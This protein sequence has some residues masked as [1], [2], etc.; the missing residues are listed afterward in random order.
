MIGN[1]CWELVEF[2]GPISVVRYSEGGFSRPEFQ[3]GR[4]ERAL[5]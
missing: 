3:E 2:N 5:N 1:E 4:E